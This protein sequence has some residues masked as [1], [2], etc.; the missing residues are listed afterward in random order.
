MVRLV[1][2]AVVLA[3]VSPVSAAE[4][5]V[6]AKLVATPTEAV[7]EMAVAPGWHVNAHEPRDKFLIPTTLALTPPDGMRAGEVAWPSPLERKLAFGGD[8]ALLLYEGTVRLAAPLTGT[9]VDCCRRPP[10]SWSSSPSA[11]PGSP[12]SSAGPP[13]PC[14][15]SCSPSAGRRSSTPR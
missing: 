11:L 12:P 14:G 4:E 8:K 7:V 6:R 1:L 15:S 9:P 2:L 13:R 10:P 3:S 5:V